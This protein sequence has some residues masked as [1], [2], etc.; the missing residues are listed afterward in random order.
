MK[1]LWLAGAIAAIVTLLLI[2][3]ARD[4]KME[5]MEKARADSIAAAQRAT[6]N[7]SAQQYAAPVAAEFPISGEGHATR[8][9]PVKAWLD[10][11]HSQIRPSRPERL[12]LAED[13]AVCFNDTAGADQSKVRLIEQKWEEMPAGKYLIYPLRDSV[14]FVR[15]W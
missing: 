10:P 4:K 7:R 6:A 3:G 11:A 14:V 9:S 5:K 1:K 2:G 12:C 13:P 8:E 15:W